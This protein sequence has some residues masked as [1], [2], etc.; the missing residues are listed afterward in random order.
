MTRRAYAVAILKP[1]GTAFTITHWETA[2][3]ALEQFSASLQLAG[4]PEQRI[5]HHLDAWLKALRR[6]QE[7][8]SHEAL[9]PDL[10]GSIRISATQSEG[11]RMSIK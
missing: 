8:A 6:G 9:N 1:D 5:K 11:R 2:E 3:A 4:H 7:A 10:Q